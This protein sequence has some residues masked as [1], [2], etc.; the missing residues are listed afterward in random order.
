MFST[1]F[2]RSRL[3][4]IYV[5]STVHVYPETLTRTIGEEGLRKTFSKFYHIHSESVV[6]NNIGLQTLLQQGIFKSVL[7]VILLEILILV[8]NLKR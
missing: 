6:K 8:I 5:S 4:F 1:I 3:G 7:T 2:R